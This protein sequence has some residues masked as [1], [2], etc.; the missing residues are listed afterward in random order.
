[1]KRNGM[2]TRPGPGGGPE[3]GGRALSRGRGH[4]ERGLG[5]DLHLDVE[6]M[7]QTGGEAGWEEPVAWR[8]DQGGQC[9]AAVGPVGCPVLGFSV[10]MGV[11][12]TALTSQSRLGE[13]TSSYKGPRWL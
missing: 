7:G 8:G 3:E 13:E 6:W 2:D 4:H 1:M 9:R 11:P 10:S 12:V 5:S